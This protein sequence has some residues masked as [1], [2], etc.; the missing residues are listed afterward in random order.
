[1]DGASIESSLEAHLKESK[2][3][4]EEIESCLEGTDSSADNSELLELKKQLEVSVEETEAALLQLKKDRLL[5]A[6]DV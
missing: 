2:R 1:M 6:V 3:A 5:E 4:L